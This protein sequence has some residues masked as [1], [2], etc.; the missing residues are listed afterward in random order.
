MFFFFRC[1]SLIVNR[2]LKID[3]K[4]I[5]SEHD[6]FICLNNI[7]RISLVIEPYQNRYDEMEIIF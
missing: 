5:Q 3:D 4:I 1:C 7:R 2:N 6:A